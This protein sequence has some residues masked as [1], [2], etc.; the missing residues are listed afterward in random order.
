VAVPGSVSAALL[1]G[2]LSTPIVTRQV[3][4]KQFTAGIIDKIE[5]R[6]RELILPIPRSKKTQEAV[7][8][9]V[10]EIVEERARLRDRARQITIE[11]EG[12]NIIGEDD[13]PAEDLTL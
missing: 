1:L 3:R 4:S 10:R 13:E 12:T 6:Y 5:D 8:K 2:V 9:A 11:I 7:A